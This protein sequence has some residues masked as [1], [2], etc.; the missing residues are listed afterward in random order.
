MLWSKQRAAWLGR[1]PYKDKKRRS[2]YSGRLFFSRS[3]PGLGGA[4][5][6]VELGDGS[7]NAEAPGED[8]EGFEFVGDDVLVGGGGGG[9][10]CF[11]HFIGLQGEV[12]EEVA[13]ALNAFLAA[14]RPVAGDEESIFVPGCEG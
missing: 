5:F 4:H 7:G 12:I 2:E 14:D 1:R 9:N 3:L 13:K 8:R 11:V 10:A 6:S